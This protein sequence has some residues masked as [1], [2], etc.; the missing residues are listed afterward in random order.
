MQNIA[1]V[2]SRYLS[3]INLPSVNIIDVIEIIL[4]SFFIYQFMIWI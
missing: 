4:I 3:D 1:G 2:L